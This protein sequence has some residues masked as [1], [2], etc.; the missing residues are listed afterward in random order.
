MASVNKIK[1]RVELKI[2]PKQWRNREIDRPSG[3]ADHVIAWNEKFVDNELYF[4]GLSTS[5]KIMAS[6]NPEVWHRTKN[7]PIFPK[8]IYARN[9]M[10]E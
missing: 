1:N 8:D 6:N 5:V 10:I 9:V 4:P 3:D 7:I 2:C